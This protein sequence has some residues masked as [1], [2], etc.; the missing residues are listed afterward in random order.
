MSVIT[1][2]TCIHIEKQVQ[3]PVYTS[4]ALA[5]CVWGGGGDE[6]HVLWR[7]SSWLESIFRFVCTHCIL[8][9]GLTS[10]CVGGEGAR[11]GESH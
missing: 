9:T 5:T 2:I 4:T 11:G 8:S 7:K 3:E 10:K 6:I 1:F